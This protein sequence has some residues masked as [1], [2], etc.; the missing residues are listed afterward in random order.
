MPAAHGNGADAVVTRLSD[1]GAVATLAVTGDLSNEVKN[2]ERAIARSLRSGAAVVID[3]RDCSYCDSA[4]LGLIVNQQRRS[5]GRFAIV[6]GDAGP[7]RRIF[8]IT[9]LSN[10]LAI[11]RDADEARLF[12]EAHRK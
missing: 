2:L 12:L 11:A 7:V 6:L 3:L 4:T 10:R 9:G 8:E 5:P 1:G